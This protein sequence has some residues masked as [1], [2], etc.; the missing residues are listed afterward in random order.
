MG[1]VIVTRK[2]YDIDMYSIYRINTQL[3]HTTYTHV[4]THTHA[5]KN[6]P[7]QKPACTKPAYIKTCLYK[8]LPIQKPAYTKTCLYKNLPIQKPAYTN[9]QVIMSS[10]IQFILGVYCLLM[11][12]YCYYVN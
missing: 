4:H 6:L 8:N 12:V 5:Y 9:I 1:I 11:F 2:D 3:Q 10:Q 7:V